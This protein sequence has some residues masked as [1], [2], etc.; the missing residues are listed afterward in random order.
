MIKSIIFDVDDTL[1]DFRSAHSAALGTLSAFVES[2]LGVSP[3][4]F[5]ALH[6]ETFRLQ[7]ARLGNT[8]A[9]HNRLIRFQ[10]MLEALNKPV[11]LAPSMAELYWSALLA[12]VRP[13]PGAAETMTQLR[14]RGM[15]I[16]VGTNMT[17][18]WQFAKLQ[19]LGMM[20]LID[21]IVTSEEA[22][23]EKPDA[24]LFAL[25]ARKAGCAMFECAFVGDS[26]KGDALG[27][28]DA[29]MR[30][31]WLYRGTDA[32]DAPQGVVRIRALTEL[33][34]LMDTQ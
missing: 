21:F 10:M 34:A 19:R 7:E 1:Y 24:G 33:P 18:D 25:C 12:C 22:G 23:V 4:A 3:E 8:A 16:G 32:P 29:G 6:G 13:L 28:R 9:S 31:F 17:A 14:D 11:A 27:A 30:A 2:A 5:I 26:L 20:P 15:T